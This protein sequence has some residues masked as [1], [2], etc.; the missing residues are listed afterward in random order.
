MDWRSLP[1]LNSLKTFAAV[2]ETRNLSAAGRELNVTH[3][4]VSQQVKSLENFLGLQLVMREGRGIALSPE[5]E[6]LFE[7]LSR[8]FEAIVETVEEL[9]REDISRPLNITVTPSFA[10][11][12]LMPRINDFR[13]KHPDI[14]LMLNPTAEVV[15]LKPGG[16]DLAVRFG[17]GD[18]PGLESELFICTNFAVVG[19]SCLIGDKRIEKPEDILEFPW[20]S[21]Y[22][23]NELTMWMERQ[24]VVPCCKLNITHMPGY[25]VLEGVRRGEGISATAKM[26]LE[27][28]IATGNLKVLFEEGVYPGTGYHLVTRHGVKRPPLKAFMSWLRTL[29]PDLTD[30]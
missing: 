18:W 13:L 21:E 22:G 11:S 5:G 2:A 20:L 19:A 4:A 27:A 14:E 12:W 9:L 17:K 3:A 16:V 7:G 23:T 10:I 24:G 6:Q 25:M 1:S 15:E 26:F 8:G 28:D 30:C 29:R